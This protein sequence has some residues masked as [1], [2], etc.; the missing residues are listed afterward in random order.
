VSTLQSELRAVPELKQQIGERD[1]CGGSPACCWLLGSSLGLGLGLAAPCCWGLPLTPVPPAF[2]ARSLVDELRKALEASVAD[3]SSLVRQVEQAAEASRQLQ[4]QI[5]RLQQ[6]ATA[7]EQVRPA[8]LLSCMPPAPGSAGH[9]R[10]PAPP[11]PALSPCPLAARPPQASG[12]LRAEVQRLGADLAAREQRISSL[13]AQVSER[14]AQLAAANATVSEREAQLAAARNDFRSRDDKVGLRAG[15][16]CAGAPWPAVRPRAARPERPVCTHPP[17]A[18]HTPP[19]TLPPT[20]P[21]AQASSLLAELEARERELAQARAD[22]A[23]KDAR[24]SA[25]VADVEAREARL[26]VRR[27]VSL[28][29]GAVVALWWRCGGWLPVPWP[30]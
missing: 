12:P 9:S 10:R 15:Q 26:Q 25:L 2:G 5:A 7:T 18:P 14:E 28:G 8:A 22:A 16:C 6:Q 20:H 21:L 23:N 19:P 29:C 27:F 24:L 30:G 4:D 1:R 11:G 13:T 3:N 17:L